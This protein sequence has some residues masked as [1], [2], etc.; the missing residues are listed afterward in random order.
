MGLLYGI[1]DVLYLLG[2]KL[3]RYRKGIVD[4]N[5]RKSFPEKSSQELKSIRN[6][7]YR[8]FFDFVMESLKGVT[9]DEKNIREMVHFKNPEIIHDLLKNRSVIIL[10]SHFFSWELQGM[11]MSLI[12]DAKGFYSYQKLNSE[13]FNK[14]MIQVR[15]K[16]GAIGIRRH[17]M[18]K[19]VFKHR[20]DRILIFILADQ[21]PFGNA[22]RY[23]VKFL[24]QPTPFYQGI[25]KVAT[26]GNFQVVSSFTKR[27]SRGKYEVEFKLISGTDEK[28]DDASILR[29]YIKQLEEVVQEQPQNWLWTH[30]R[31][32]K[33]P[34][35]GDSIAK[36]LKMEI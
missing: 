26:L 25:G 14:M 30:K 36:D 9:I 4:Q 35:K 24:N 20:N 23:W 8:S 21:A 22:K 10:G 5:I 1:S 13:T 17:E 12:F 6:Q 32:K 29:T 16:F 34:R 31:W 2:Y 27:I 3:F 11:A 15:G 33:N 28:P 19:V 7:F 18:P